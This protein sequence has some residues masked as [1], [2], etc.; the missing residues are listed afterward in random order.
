M[1]RKE[2]LMKESGGHL[3]DS[4]ESLESLTNRRGSC[5]SMFSDLR[6]VIIDEVHYFHAGCR[7]PELLGVNWSGLKKLKGV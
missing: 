2:K 4:P 1:D 6:F 5:L 7:G 3:A